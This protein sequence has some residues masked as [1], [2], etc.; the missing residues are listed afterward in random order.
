M[1]EKNLL[2]GWREWAKLP[3]LSIPLIKAKIDTGA[4]TSVLH[5]YDI[6]IIKQT[7]KELA[8]FIVHPLQRNDKICRRCRAEIVGMRTIK[9]SSGHT[10]DRIVVRSPIQIGDYMWDI[11]ITLTNRDIMNHRMLIGRE[12]MSDLIVDPTKSFR[13]G[14]ISSKQA[15]VAYEPVIMD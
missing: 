12:A 15:S 11:N 13:Q 4:K 7:G 3:D 5:A 8:E 1:K 14:L 9:S 6:K 2:V 10:E